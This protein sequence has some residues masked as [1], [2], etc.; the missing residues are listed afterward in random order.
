MDGKNKEAFE[1]FNIGTGHGSSVR[2]V[3]DTFMKVTGVKLPYRIVGRRKGDI[4]AVWADTTKA[5]T[6]LGWKARLTM[7]DALRDAWRWEQKIRNQNKDA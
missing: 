2:E 5:E 4:T 3:V 1:V 7:A 6:K